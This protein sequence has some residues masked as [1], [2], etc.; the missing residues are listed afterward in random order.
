MFVEEKL[1][2]KLSE[3]YASDLADFYTTRV[4]RC[5]NHKV[6]TSSIWESFRKPFFAKKI[7][8]K[9][10]STLAYIISLCKKQFSG[11]LLPNACT[12]A[13]SDFR[14]VISVTKYPFGAKINQIWDRHFR[15]FLVR[16]YS[17]F[18]KWRLEPITRSSILTTC[19][20]TWILCRS[21]H[22]SSTPLSCCRSIH[23]VKNAEIHKSCWNDVTTQ[24]DSIATKS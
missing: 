24:F 20:S 8:W 3:V 6:L 14:I 16:K 22:S 4:F 13:F 17:T 11:S 7:V 2:R 19:K 10:N 9:W 12:W 23:R 5:V 15:S 21:L 1:T 18:C